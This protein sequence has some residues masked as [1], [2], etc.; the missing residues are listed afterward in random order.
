[1]ESASGNCALNVRKL[2]DSINPRSIARC[3]HVVS[4]YPQ[5]AI[6]RGYDVAGFL[7]DNRRP[8]GEEGLAS[9]ILVEAR[10][11]SASVPSTTE[12]KLNRLLVTRMGDPEDLSALRTKI[13]SLLGH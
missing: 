8:Q 6:E 13:N 5:R 1:M 11:T 7:F 2:I 12:T 4:P 10:A 3:G 9:R